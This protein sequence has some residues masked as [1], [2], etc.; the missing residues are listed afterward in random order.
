MV[1]RAQDKLCR[2]QSF[3]WRSCN[4]WDFIIGYITEVAV[5]HLLQTVAIVS[6]STIHLK[7]RLN[8]ISCAEESSQT[9]FP[10]SNVTVFKEEQE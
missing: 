10:K 8:Q 2:G 1:Y 3:L 6:I 4:E 9:A 7:T 5:Y